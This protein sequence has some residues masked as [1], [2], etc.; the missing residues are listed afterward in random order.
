VPCSIGFGIGYIYLC[1]QYDISS[2]IAIPVFDVSGDCISTSGGGTTT[3]VGCLDCGGGLVVGGPVGGGGG[4]GT[5]ELPP[6]IDSSP[7]SCDQCMAKAVL[8]C[9]IGYTPVGCAYGA[10][11]CYGNV[12]VQGINASTAENCIQQGVGCLGPIGNTASCLWS[13]LRCKF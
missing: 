9:A 3:T 12:G 4:G 5:V 8:E 10:W 13:F 2:G 11:S 7:S 1:G 6:E